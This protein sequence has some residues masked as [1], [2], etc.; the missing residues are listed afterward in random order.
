[1][2]PTR[3][4]FE[5]VVYRKMGKISTFNLRVE[6]KSAT[7]DLTAKK[8]ANPKFVFDLQQGQFS[9]C[10]KYDGKE[11]SHFVDLGQL[12]EKKEDCK[13]QLVFCFNQKLYV[14]GEVE[15]DVAVGSGTIGKGS[16]QG[17]AARSFTLDQLNK[18]IEKRKVLNILEQDIEEKTGFD[19][20]E[21]AAVG[22]EADAFKA[23]QLARKT[24]AGDIIFTNWS[25]AYKVHQANVE[26]KCIPFTPRYIDGR[27][28]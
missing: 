19:K 8:T 27:R 13:E 23:D 16:S 22:E 20:Q 2:F 21:N 17:K 10:L 9:L 4:N 1:M 6:F 11:I 24:A 15:M 3:N 14:A 12:K 7:L 18:I 5:Y 26:N 25:G 28:I